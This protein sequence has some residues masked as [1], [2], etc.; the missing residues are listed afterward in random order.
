MHTGGFIKVTSF[1]SLP[2]YD[3]YNTFETGYKLNIEFQKKK[4]PIFYCSLIKLILLKIDP[5]LSMYLFT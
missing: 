3:I 4:C 1:S 5:L 2:K